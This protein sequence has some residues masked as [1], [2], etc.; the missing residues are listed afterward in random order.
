MG[1][2]EINKQKMHFSFFLI[3]CVAGLTRVNVPH[4]IVDDL[5]IALPIKLNYL[6]DDGYVNFLIY[7]K[8]NGAQQRKELFKAKYSFRSKMA[9][10]NEVAPITQQSYQVTN[11]GTHLLMDI[12]DVDLYKSEIKFFIK[13][14]FTANN[15]TVS[16]V[17]EYLYKIE[18]QY[19]AYDLS[20]LV[21]DH[22]LT[23][24]DFVGLY[25]FYDEVNG[26]P[27][28][29]KGDL[30]FKF[31]EEYN[32]WII[33]SV[34]NEKLVSGLELLQSVAIN[35]KSHL[36]FDN[37]AWLIA[38]DGVWKEFEM[39]VML[40]KKEEI[41]YQEP[42]GYPRPKTI[43]ELTRGL[44]DCVL[45][46]G[47]NG[48]VIFESQHPY[49][50]ST[51]CDARI[52]CQGNEKPTF[53]VESFDLEDHESCDYDYLRISSANEFGLKCGHDVKLHHRY[54]TNQQDILMQFK[55][56]QAK[57]FDG[58]KLIAKCTAETSNI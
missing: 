24:Y 26:Y 53:L 40:T 46:A 16:E 38:I 51:Y 50:S 44:N 39:T 25:K 10:K 13:E 42:D 3:S 12:S 22:N 41:S 15:E 35:M 2:R 56:D 18:S 17:S 33:E 5:Q 37:I 23:K 19:Y 6:T 45:E 43:F 28:F 27:Q 7:F 11:N 9:R 30:I 4:N 49:S 14:K 54:Q 21:S 29:K 34:S 58:F 48:T 52:T 8:P 55:S 20:V 31:N 36:N 32:R 1:S 47:S 57:E